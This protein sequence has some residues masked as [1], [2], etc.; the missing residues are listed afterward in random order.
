[1]HCID[2]GLLTETLD[3]CLAHTYAAQAEIET[4][5]ESLFVAAEKISDEY[6][7]IFER[8]SGK[9]GNGIGSRLPSVRVRAGTNG[10]TLEI[11]WMRS[12]SGPSG[13]IRSAYNKG[14]SN[15]YNTA[16]ITKGSPDW[17][18]ELVR[19]TEDQFAH[20]RMMY[21][22]LMKLKSITHQTV[23]HAKLES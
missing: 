10:K 1:M 8:T 12:I 6:Y 18:Q 21:K 13:R 7:S 3:N 16:K 17:E 11:R 20:I 5:L 4:A 15:R 9:E 14:Q 19:T 22:D 2:D 23:K